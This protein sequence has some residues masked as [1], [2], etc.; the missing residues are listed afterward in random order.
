MHPC[1]VQHEKGLASD[2]E[3]QQ[4]QFVENEICVNALGRCLEKAAVVAA[5][6][7]ETVDF[8]AFFGGDEHVLT[9]EL[10]AVGSIARSANMDF[11]PIEEV[12]QPQFGQLFE[13]GQAS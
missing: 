1:A 2:L 5:D 13:F 10:P 12:E 6:K 9:R 4:F 3:R 8:R 7:A 11:V